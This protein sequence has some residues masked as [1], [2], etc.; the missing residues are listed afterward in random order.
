[1]ITYS[2][3]ILNNNDNTYRLQQVI[4][5]RFIFG[6][7]WTAKVAFRVD[8]RV[9]RGGPLSKRYKEV[10]VTIA[11]LLYHYVLLLC[12]VYYWTFV[13]HICCSY[14]CLGAPYLGGPL[15]ISLY[16]PI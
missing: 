11:L 15:T 8:T 3:S 16:V 6:V 7:P 5:L 2:I 10:T 9:G 13:I 14:I 1:M 12:I 4:R